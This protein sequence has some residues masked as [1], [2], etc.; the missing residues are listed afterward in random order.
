MRFTEHTSTRL[1]ALA[2]LEKREVHRDMAPKG[3]G[4][5]GAAER[6]GGWREEFWGLQVWSTV[7]V[8]FSIQLPVESLFQAIGRRRRLGGLYLFFSQMPIG[9]IGRRGSPPCFESMAKK[10]KHPPST[11]K[12]SKHRFSNAQR[13]AP[14]EKPSVFEARSGRLKFDVLGKKTRGVRGDALKA[15]TAGVTKRRNTL[16]KEHQGLGSANVFSDRR[17]GE[18]DVDMTPE[19]RS[20]GR[21]ARARLRQLRPGK[22]FALNEDDDDGNG[23]GSF[24]DV[25]DAKKASSSLTHGGAPIDPKK[26]ERRSAHYL[27]RGATR[28]RGDESDSDDD[29]D[30]GGIGR[31]AT[32]AMHFGGGGGGDDDDDEHS[33]GFSLKRSDHES[34]LPERRKTKKEVMEE[35]IAKSKHGKATRFVLYFPNQAA[36][37][38][39]LQD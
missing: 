36:H 5:R 21:L 10:K 34:D 31:D 32:A 37:C 3:N 20:I 23:G 28:R 19:E 17:F 24:H 13:E 11:G 12:K 2:P 29:R 18:G 26:E 4:T 25:D 33:G 27:A 14:V 15:R 38:L 35:L 22:S 8:F 30:G 9:H 7:F 6:C 1:P 39:L 16:L